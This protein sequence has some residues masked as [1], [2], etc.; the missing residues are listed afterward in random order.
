MMKLGFAQFKVQNAMEET[1]TDINSK[2]E[3]HL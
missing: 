3:G 2:L 1:W